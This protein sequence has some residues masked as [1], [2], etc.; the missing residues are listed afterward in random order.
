MNRAFLTQPDTR[1]GLRGALTRPVYGASATTPETGAPHLEATAPAPLAVSGGHYAWLNPVSASF[2]A[3]SFT[4]GPRHLNLVLPEVTPGAVFAGVKTAIEV[5]AGLS[6]LSGLPVRLVLIRPDLVASHALVTKIRD[7]LRRVAGLEVEIIMSQDLPGFDFGRSDLWIA[8][9][10]WTAH[11][12]DIACRSG[13]VSRERVI[14]LIQDYEAGFTPWSTDSALAAMTYGAGFTPIVN[15]SP[16]ADYLESQ[17]SVRVDRDRV[18]SPSFDLNQLQNAALHREPSDHVRVF[19]YGR[20]ARPRN[21][22]NLGLS[23]LQSLASELSDRHLPF[24]IV[25]AGENGPNVE[26][27]AA[28][29]TNLG[30]LSRSDYFAVL[31]R[32]DVGLSLQYSPH[33]SHPPFDIAISGALAV[34]NDFG[35]SRNGLH[36]NLRAVAPD[37]DAL[38]GALVAASLDA[39]NEGPGE[40]TPPREG[41][42]GRAME[43]ALAATWATVASSLG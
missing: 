9:H 36:P 26:L 43:D 34:T 12:L 18:F 31:S 14:Y 8:T 35:G 42:L 33:P 2:L 19:F 40:F 10:W 27:G 1:Q 21:L 41:G 23:A 24:E 15:S 11:A 22:F 5:A 17:G 30:V 25:M 37:P 28:T 38:A 6:D 7:E 39:R 3:S 20:P 13:L 29:V 16:L 32:V 4:A